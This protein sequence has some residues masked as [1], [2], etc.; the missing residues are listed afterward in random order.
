MAEFL[1]K[2]EGLNKTAIGNFLGERYSP[3][4]LQERY[5]FKSQNGNFSIFYFILVCV[6]EQFINVLSVVFI[7]FFLFTQGGDAPADIE[8]LCGLA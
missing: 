2:E 3:L 4:I 8:G 1:Y 5:L 6:N 7:S